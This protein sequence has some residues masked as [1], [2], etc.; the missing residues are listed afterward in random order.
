MEIRQAKISELNDVMQFYYDITDDMKGSEFKP[1]WEKDVYPTRE[2]VQNAIQNDELFIAVI[3]KTVVASMILNH[4][5][6]DG[7]ENASWNISA[8]PEEIISIHALGVSVKQ[9]GKGISKQMVQKAIDYC[10]SQNI[11]AIRLDVLGGNIPASKLYES[12]G[13]KYIE[14]LKLFY[15]DTGLTDFLL[16]ELVL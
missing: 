9:Q 16:Y 12:M 8:T 7:Y 15:E 11:K 10:M 13:F 1:G 6:T 3:D 2:A 14:T 5:C 4:E